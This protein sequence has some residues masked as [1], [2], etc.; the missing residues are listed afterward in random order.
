VAIA[1]PVPQN[2][3]TVYHIHVQVDDL[4]AMTFTT[5]IGPVTGVSNAQKDT[6]A[7]RLVD[8]YQGHPQL[9][10]TSAEKRTPVSQAITPDV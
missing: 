4:P 9:T 5:T 10:V 1:A 2:N 7:Q 6:I 8:L 3:E